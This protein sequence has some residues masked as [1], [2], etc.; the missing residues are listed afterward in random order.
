LVAVNDS[1]VIEKLFPP[2]PIAAKTS[3]I[4]SGADND[5]IY[6]VSFLLRDRSNKTLKNDD[7]GLQRMVL[8]FKLI[9]IYFNKTEL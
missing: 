2:E 6:F 7:Y 3:N 1:L 8:S 4:S 9:F 5:K